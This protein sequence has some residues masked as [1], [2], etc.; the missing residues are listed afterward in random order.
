MKLQFLGSTQTVDQKITKKIHGLR[1]H[2][3]FT[4]FPVSGQIYIRKAWES[5]KWVSK[6]AS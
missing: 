5:M 2:P 1:S 3:F 4:I 6:N